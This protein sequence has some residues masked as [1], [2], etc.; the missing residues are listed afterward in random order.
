MTPLVI[1]VIVVIKEEIL[2][3]AKPG[4]RG[5]YRDISGMTSV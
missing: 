1:A 5:G 3:L 4:Q 2:I